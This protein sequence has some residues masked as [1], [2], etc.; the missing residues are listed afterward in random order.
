MNTTKKFEGTINEVLKEFKSDME[1]IAS[2]WNGKN[3]G[4]EEDMAMAAD[5]IMEHIDD[6]ENVLNDF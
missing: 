3:P 4:R 2:T 5:E 6:I 1:A